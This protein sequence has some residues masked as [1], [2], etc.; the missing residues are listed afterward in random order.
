MFFNTVHNS[1]L[2]NF[3]LILWVSLSDEALFLVRFKLPISCCCYVHTPFVVLFFYYPIVFWYC[4]SF[5][6]WWSP[7]LFC[8]FVCLLGLLKRKFRAQPL[9]LKLRIAI[10][11]TPGG[12][13]KYWNEIN[14]DVNWFC[15]KGVTVIKIQ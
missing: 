5:F 2:C 9:Q 6:H 12:C 13:W 14:Y 11:A 1:F 15:F 4:R 7:L 8:L 10:D 3:L